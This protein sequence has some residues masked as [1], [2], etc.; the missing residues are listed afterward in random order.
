MI[1]ALLY[2]PRGSSAQRRAPVIVSVHGGPELQEQPY[3]TNYYQ[4][5]LARGFAVLAP[6]VRGST[7]YGKAYVAADNGPLRWD[8]MKDVAAAVE[9]IRRQDRL[10]GAKVACLGASYGGFITLAMLAHYPDL[11]AA[12]VDFYG[13]SDLRTFLA[14]TAEHR[15]PMRI[16]EYGDP[17]R[18]STFMAAISPA[19]HAGRIKAPLLVIQ[20]ANDPVVP[21]AESEDI[22]RLVREAG[23]TAEYLLLP[24]EGH[25][26]TKDE[27][28]IKSYDQVLAFLRR[29]MPPPGR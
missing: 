20:G 2:V 18:D 4:F 22:V 28:W 23:G 15:R 27:N 19:A 9:W 29:H 26:L 1:P 13:P 16:A 12:G 10:D 6:N 5:L 21:P 14:R 11:F 7:G 3:M 24:D 25:G 8:A 17:V